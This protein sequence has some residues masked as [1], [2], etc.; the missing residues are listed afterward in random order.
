MPW[1]PECYLKF[2]AERFAP[3]EDLLKM[4]RVR[5]GM[6]VID[7]GCGT[8]EMTR[9]L[10]DSLPGSDVLGID[11][12]QEMLEKAKDYVGPGL[13]FKSGEIE[14]IEG[15]WD[16]VFS[17]A[18]IQWVP[19][20]QALVP[21]LL[22]LL[23]PGG[24]LAVQLPSNHHHPV[25]RTIVEIADEEPFRSALNS[26]VRN[27][28]V[29]SVDEYAVLLHEHGGGEIE[30][31]EKVYPHLMKDADA[32]VEWT[33]GTV[34]LPYFDRLSS[35]VKTAFLNEYRTRL[36]GLYPTEEILYAFR[37]TLFFAMKP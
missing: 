12:S 22:A 34:L 7:L 19:D 13:G 10:S 26:W 3:F 18:A 14:S 24:Q 29:L 32:L 25:Y 23:N 31:F 35:E 16:L 9:R 15:Q 30:V 21:R 11:S 5:D 6:S 8:G 37:R 4:I 33:S 1:D 36:R 17:N 28:P 20:H 27:F 2:K